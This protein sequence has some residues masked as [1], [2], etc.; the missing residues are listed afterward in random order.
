[1]GARVRHRHHR[2]TGHAAPAGRI[3]AVGTLRHCPEPAARRR[4]TDPRRLAPRR[5]ES[6]PRQR[7]SER[8]ARAL[9]E[10]RVAGGGAADAGPPAPGAARRTRRLSARPGRAPV[11]STRRTGSSRTSATTRHQSSRR[12]RGL[13]I[14]TSSPTG[15][16]RPRS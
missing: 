15:T 4:P 5:P 10:A 9:L 13:C 2:R 16:R 14:R 1:L 12:C 6:G 3:V 8:G 11:R 7:R